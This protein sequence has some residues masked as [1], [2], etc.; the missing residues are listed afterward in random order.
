M[1]WLKGKGYYDNGSGNVPWDNMPKMNANGIELYYEIHGEGDPIVFIAGFGADHSG[2]LSLVE[3]FKN[4]YQLI[5]FDNRGAGQS[6]APPGLYSINQMADDVVA[7][8][9]QLGIFKAHFVGNSMGGFILQSLAYRHPNLVQSAIISNS[10]TTMN[11]CFQ[12][13]VAAQLEF[14]KAA[15]PMAALLKAFYAW[16]FSYRFLS[17]AGMLNALIQLGLETP[18]PFTKQGY[19]GQYAAL[20]NFDARP[21]A[22]NIS[23]PTLVLASDQ[24]LIARD[25]EVASLAQQIPNAQYFCFSECGHLPH[26]EQPEQFYKQVHLF[27][28][29]V[30]GRE[31]R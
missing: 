2:W 14:I 28:R 10:T 9:T 11:S 7:L 6:D 17:Q 13:Y 8:C 16:A 31:Q 4:S 23:V 15:V 18:F 22:G 5:L 19:E 30:S 21:W 1:L 27:I 25:Q 26:L 3:H 20:D 12:I 24:D 29:T